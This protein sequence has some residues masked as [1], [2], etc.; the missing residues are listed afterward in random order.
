[1]MFN[2]QKL[3][4]ISYVSGFLRSLK[5]NVFPLIFAVFIVMTRGLDN[6]GDLIFPIAILSISLIS[7]VFKAIKIYKTRYWIEND[8]LIMTW[9]VFSKNRKELNIERIQSVDTSQNIAHQL[10]GGV[11]LS[12]KTPSDGI[13]LDTITK[14]QSDELSKYIKERKHKL[15]NKEAVEVEPSENES[16]QNESNLAEYKP[17]EDVVFFQLSIKDLLKMSFTSGGIFI[18]FAALGSLFGF[19]SQVIDVEDYI[20]PLLN[21]IV[22]L[23]FVIISFVILFIFISYIIGSL[24]VFIRNY[25]YQLTFDGELLTVKYGL[26]TVQKR[27]VPI[28]RIQAL[29]EEESLFRRAIGY[30]KI[31][32]IITTDGQFD[33]NEETDIGNVTILPFMKKKEAYKLLEE[34]IPQFQFNSVD[35]GLPIQGIRRRIFI[36]TLILLI[37]VVP[38]QIY[39]W[40]YTWI[41][42]L[43]IFLIML[44]FAS[45]ITLKSG[46]K[47]YDDSIV[48]LNASPFEYSTIWAKRDKIL[49]FELHE[50]PIIKR[51][52]IVHFN[53]H[54]AYG[55]SMISRGM[56]FI[57]KKDALNIYN[58]YKGG[59]DDAS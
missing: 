26:L 37:A 40:S 3:H 14:K 33:S 27:T 45:V 12:V 57:H 23:T 15:K 5:E 28:R 16:E 9:G 50:N 53:I 46:F 55:D 47:V 52:D 43:V 13:E 18:V 32:A 6:I 58:W 59:R 41:I 29:K 10:L 7:S 20:S 17:K 36:P 31:S 54:L 8:Q 39:L 11:N 51:K 21:Q 44:L 34:I 25:K 30:T 19:L 35:K 49:T 24:I 1:M 2:P 56:R 22:N 38:I 4:P 48:L 42:G